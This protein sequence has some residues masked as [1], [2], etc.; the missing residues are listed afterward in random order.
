MHYLKKRKEFIP[1]AAVL[2]VVS[3]AAFDLF[4]DQPESSRFVESG[5]VVLSSHISGGAGRC[6]LPDYEDYYNRQRSG[7]KEAENA[8]QDEE[9]S[10]LNRKQDGRNF[11]GRATN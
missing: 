3:Y 10:S 6:N 9:N 8:G 4:A 1:I 7:N 5:A 2:I 11:M